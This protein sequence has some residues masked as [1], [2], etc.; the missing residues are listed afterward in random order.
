MHTIR[1]R[2]PWQRTVG[3]VTET[4][5][6]PDHSQT[7]PDHKTIETEVVYKRKFNLPTGLSETMPVYL[8]ITDW[9]ADQIVIRHNDAVIPT[10]TSARPLRVELTK[11]L[12]LHNEVTI[13][14][15]GAA[16]DGPQLIGDVSIEIDE[17]SCA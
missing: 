2:K 9:R 4:V 16:A 11:S 8:R 6:V 14:L 1:L 5:E 10:T 17:A 13:T 12:T 3:D 15:T 7:G